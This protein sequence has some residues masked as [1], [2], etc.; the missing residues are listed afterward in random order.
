MPGSITADDVLLTV[1]YLPVSSSTNINREM[2][3]SCMLSCPMDEK[4]DVF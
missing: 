3:A 1:T 2:I 4:G